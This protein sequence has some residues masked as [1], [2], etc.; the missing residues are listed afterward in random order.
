[1]RFGHIL[2][3]LT[4]FALAFGAVPAKKGTD[5]KGPAPKTTSAR[6]T[7]ARAPARKG[8]RGVPQAPSYARQ[9]QPTTDRYREI[10][11]ALA[12]KGFLKS[13]VNGVWGPESVEALKQFQEQ[14][15]LPVTGKLSSRSLM[16]LGLGP[17]VQ[18]V[19]T[20]APSA[21]VTPAVADANAPGQP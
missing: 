19:S 2:L 3:F 11:Q 8:A 16:G 12:D 7:G 9:Q 10:Q 14:N 17:R 21:P 18:A 6:R 13:E 1:M 5:R 15:Q 20:P 4:S